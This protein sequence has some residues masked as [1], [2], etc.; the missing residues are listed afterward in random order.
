V[1]T[2]HLVAHRQLALDRHVHL[3]HLDDAR[4]QVV[5][6]TEPRLALLE[7]AVVDA[8]LLVGQ[9]LDPLDGLDEVLVLFDLDL[10]QLVPR[11]V[12]EL[13]A[14]DAVTLLGEPLH[15]VGR[16]EEVLERGLAD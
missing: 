8:D 2:G 12:V 4:R 7:H 14:L 6:A 10:L 1:A 16:I 5:A 13:L 9:V 15:L 3:D 11:E